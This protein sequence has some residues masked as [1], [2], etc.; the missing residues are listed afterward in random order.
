MGDGVKV[1]SKAE[2]T[3]VLSRRRGGESNW[4]IAS[5]MSIP[6]DTIRRIGACSNK[7]FP[8]EDYM[9]YDR[10]DY[11]LKPLGEK[12]EAWDIRLSMRL[13]RLPMS[14]WAAAI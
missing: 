3:E 5:N 4:S 13:Q 1:L 10:P 6:T 14:Q 9:I 8:I 7:H 2:C 12:I 11:H